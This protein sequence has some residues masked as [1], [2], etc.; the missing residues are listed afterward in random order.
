MPVFAPLVTNMTSGA[1]GVTINAGLAGAADCNCSIPPGTTR[2]HL[3]YWPL[4]LNSTV[5]AYTPA[6]T[7]ATFQNLGPEA[8]RTSGTVGLRFEA[9]DFR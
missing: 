9:K 8:D 2:A 6:G 5:Q 4:F 3:G 1:L 7:R